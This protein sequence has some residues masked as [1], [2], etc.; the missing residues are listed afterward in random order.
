[1]SGKEGLQGGATEDVWVDV[2]AYMQACEMAGRRAGGSIY[3]TLVQRRSE[4]IHIDLVTLQTEMQ[5][6]GCKHT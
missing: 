1:L 4:Q 6:Y 5:M 3:S 2:I